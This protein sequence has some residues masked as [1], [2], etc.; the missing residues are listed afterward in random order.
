MEDLWKQVLAE[1]QV[2]VSPPIFLGFFKPTT[3]TSLI[4][5]V[6]T[7]DSPTH[8]IAEYVEKRYYSLL[9]RVLDK[10]TGENVS[11]VFTSGNSLRGKPKKSEGPL[12]AEL[13]RENTAK[14]RPAR[15]RPDYTFDTVAVSDSNQLAYTAALT[16]AQDPGGKYNPLFLYGTVG[17]GKTHLMNAIANRVFDDGDNKK[18]IYMTTEEFTNEVVEAIMKKTTTD[19]R[20]R[21]R[22]VDLLLLDDIQ[23]LSGKD[24]VQEELFHTFNTLIDQGKQIVMSSDRP[25]AEIKKLE[26]R[27][28]SR[29]EGGL[30]VDIEAPDFELRC[31]ILLIKSRKYGINLSIDAVKAISEKIEDARALE[32]FLLRIASVGVNS[33]AEI[34]PADISALLDK[35]KA[36]QIVFRPDTIVDAICDYFNVKSTQLK[37]E[38]RDSFLITPRHICMFLLKEETR[39]TYVEIGNL[40]GGRDHSTVMH[41][42]EKMRKSVENSQAT[43]EEI[44]LIKRKIREDFVH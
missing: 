2:E 38:R 28:A 19:L 5:S 37:G 27:L 9:K 41:A 6:A 21:F 30:S 8:I 17:V 3:L 13:A 39:L 7:I 15:I 33:G 1:V 25:P 36:T 40:L 14:I 29:F 4:D 11:L 43:R 31:A 20:R 23:F 42:V 24:K 12:F 32:G 18:I 35:N 22:G 26:A 34:G 44:S 16:V 10:K